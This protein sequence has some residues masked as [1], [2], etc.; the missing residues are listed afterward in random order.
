MNEKILIV[1]DDLDTVRMVGLMLQR[2]GYQIVAASNGEQALEKATTVSPDLILLD[3]MMPGMDGFEVARKI[4]SNPVTMDIP[5]LMLTAKT[6]LDDKVNGFEAGADDYL[7][8]PIHASELQVHIKALLNRTKRKPVDLPQEEAKKRGFVI[9]FL[10]ARGGLGMTTS[11]V[12]LGSA[13]VLKTRQEIIMAE[14]RPGFG[15]LAAELRHVESDGLDKILKADPKSITREMVKDKLYKHPGGLNLLLASS[16]PSDASLVSARV[17]FNRLV[18]HLGYL[19]SFT[20]LDLGAGL[21]E[22]TQE[23]IKGCDHLIVMVESN[24]NSIAHTKG[25]LDNLNGLGYPRPR[26]TPLLVNRVRSETQMLWTYVQDR[27]ESPIPVIIMPSPEII[28]QASREGKTVVDFQ[29]GSSFSLQFVK[30]AELMIEFSKQ[31]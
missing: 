27:L 11:A 15:T 31:N 13:L 5:I 20:I 3:I 21:P 4:R 6:Q 8:K 19:A 7:T 25:L 10:A 18:E 29:P 28:Y 16:R 30:L 1:D 12:N 14:L 23:L 24:H 17:Q 26:I 9:G 2:S 22:L